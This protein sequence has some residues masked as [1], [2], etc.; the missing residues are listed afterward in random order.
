M[1]E[2][3]AKILDLAVNQGIW[4]VLYIYLFFRMLKDTKERE[5]QMMEQNSQREEAYQQIIERL[6][7]SIETRIA[8]IQ[9]TLNDMSSRDQQSSP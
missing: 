9:E 2:L 3:I 1:D 7:S 4:A 5:A 8:I 6:S